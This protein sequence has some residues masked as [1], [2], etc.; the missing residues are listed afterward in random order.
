MN[1]DTA[2]SNSSVCFQLSTDE[3]IELQNIIMNGFTIKLSDLDSIVWF[4]HTIHPI[5]AETEGIRFYP[6]MQFKS[7]IE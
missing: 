2:T 1:L 5:L 4:H 7:W 3:T 6:Q